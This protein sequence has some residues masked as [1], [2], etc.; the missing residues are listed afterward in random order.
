MTSLQL[1]KNLTTAAYWLTKNTKENPQSKVDTVNSIL[2]LYE[3]G[4]IKNVDFTKVEY[5]LSDDV[6]NFFDAYKLAIAN[7]SK[8]KQ[9]VVYK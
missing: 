9:V 3:Q 4:K 1:F 5:K 2:E 7:S 6:N 8:H